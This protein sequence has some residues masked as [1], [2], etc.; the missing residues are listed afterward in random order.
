MLQFEIKFGFQKQLFDQSSFILI[1]PI[2]YFK[3]RYGVQYAGLHCCKTETYRLSDE[4]SM[5][6]MK[7]S[8]I[9]RAEFAKVS[10]GI[11]F[12]RQ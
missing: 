3:K 11:S 8:K 10:G 5:S 9:R 6:Q 4:K 1:N 7:N 2:R 12:L